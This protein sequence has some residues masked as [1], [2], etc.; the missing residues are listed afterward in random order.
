MKNP[1]KLKTV[2]A[3]LATNR[4][5]YVHVDARLPEVI[6]PE[7]LTDRPQVVLAI[8]HNMATPIPDLVVNS[9]G[10]SGTLSFDGV[11]YHVFVPWVA[12][13]AALIPTGRGC[14]WSED[15]P[16]EVIT[17]MKRAKSGVAE[18]PRAPKNRPTC[19]PGAEAKVISLADYRARKG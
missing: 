14:V 9:F 7:H 8:G 10:V 6:L 4:D 3:M 5:V 13:F 19:A 2:R 12:L 16:A 15:V 17:S 1:D 18:I 11:G